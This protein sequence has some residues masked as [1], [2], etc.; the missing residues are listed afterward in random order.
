MIAYLS[1]AD[2]ASPIGRSF[3]KVRNG[4]MRNFDTF[5]DWVIPPGLAVVI[6]VASAWIVFA[7]I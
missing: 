7:P 4:P 2:A 6:A 1:G 5:V 3:A